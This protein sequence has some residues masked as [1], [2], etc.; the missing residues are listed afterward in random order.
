MTAQRVAFLNETA[1]PLG[2]RVERLPA[3]TAATVYRD[4]ESLLAGDAATISTYLKGYEAA[5]STPPETCR[6][7]KGSTTELVD[8]PWLWGPACTEC[9]ERAIETIES[10][11]TALSYR[12]RQEAAS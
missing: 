10:E 3:G 1:Q 2:L 9:A 4:D 5:T 6:F 12:R 11:V 7:C 8:S